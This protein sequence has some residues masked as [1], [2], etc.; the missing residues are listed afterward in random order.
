MAE[1]KQQEHATGGHEDHAAH[2]ERPRGLQT[3][4]LRFGHSSLCDGRA[5]AD[6]K[7]GPEQLRG[8]PCHASVEPVGE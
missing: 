8:L 4:P 2:A 5:C 6:D 7:I 1:A 3:A